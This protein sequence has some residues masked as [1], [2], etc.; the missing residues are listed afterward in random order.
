MA[1]P[2]GS[3]PGQSALLAD[4][5]F[6]LPPEFKRFAA[7]LGLDRGGDQVDKKVLGLT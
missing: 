7:C 6:V 1:A 2:L 5:C 3:E 4:P